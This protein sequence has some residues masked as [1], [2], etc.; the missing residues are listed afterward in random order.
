MHKLFVLLLLPWLAIF[1]QTLR[2]SILTNGAAAG[3][4]IDTYTAEGRVSCSYEFN[5]RGRGPKLS[6]EYVLGPDS[7]PVRTDIT[8][9]DYL[10]APVNEHFLRD[11]G[12]S[13]WNSTA[14]NGQDKG[15]GFY[16]SINGP[17]AET[18][19]LAGALLKAKAGHLAL[20]PSGDAYLDRLAEV[21]LENSGRKIHVTEYAM[22]GLGFDPSTVWLDDD[23]K[24]FAFPG[25]W[26]ATLREGW[27][28]SNQQLCELELKAAD[29]R[30]GR[31]AR[32]FARKPAGPVAVEHVRLFDA[33]G[34]AARDD[35]TVIVQGERVTSVGPSASVA[36]P[37]G[38]ERIDGR[39]KTLLPGLFDMHAHAQSGDGI[40]NIASGVTSVRDMGN[41]IE[42][43]ARLQRQ[44]DSG[45]AIGPRVFKSG[46]IDGRGPFQAPTGLYADDADEVRRAV[47]RY[48]DLGYVQIKLYSSLKPELAPV[49]AQAAHERGL[50]LSGHVPNGM[51]AREFVEAGADEL[52]HI[53][54]LFLNFLADKVKDTRTPERF[55]AVGEFASGLD[56]QSQAVQDFVRFLVTHRTTADLTLVAFESKYTGRPGKVSADFAPVLKRLPAQVQRSAYTGGLPAAGAKDQLYRDSYR[57]ML[58][59]TKLLY[60]A[61]VPIL[62]G[63]DSIAGIMLHREVELEVAAG[64]PAAKALQ[65][66]TIQAARVL[67]Q[68]GELGSIAVGKY[69]D[70]LLVDGNPTEKISDIRL[71][72]LVMKNG[73]LYTPADVYRSAGIAPAVN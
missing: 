60:D 53:N 73:T 20:F 9:V 58:K 6:A 19:F 37:A 41:D 27:E 42:V 67:K 52:Q 17:G 28:D 2:Y 55:T 33:E 29:E 3:N 4:E 40:L 68:D 8:G 16:V 1:S 26:F 23:G 31:L 49:A 70:M 14:E 22:T 44:W 18:A 61:G 43:L 10:K 11:K 56:L 54:F 65:I 64:I 34:A 50:R 24:F 72:R 39:G 47:A 15:S 71:G 13:R 32:R 35:Q 25:K 12:I 21:T 5:D 38:V 7:K 62:A 46:F 66:A 69:A 45:S 30:Y 63:T 36:M 57:A 48:A 51:I 59:M